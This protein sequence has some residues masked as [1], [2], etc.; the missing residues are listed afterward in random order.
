VGLLEDSHVLTFS[1]QVLLDHLGGVFDGVVVLFSL[2]VAEGQVQ[3]D[4][5][6][7]ITNKVNGLLLGLNDLNFTLVIEDHLEREEGLVVELDGHS[8]AAQAIFFVLHTVDADVP[9]HFLDVGDLALLLR[10]LRGVA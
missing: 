2:D 6:L 7:H 8:V 4:G 3:A 5:D 10:G 1:R 9:V